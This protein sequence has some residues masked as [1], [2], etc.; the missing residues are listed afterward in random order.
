MMKPG[1]IKVVAAV[2]FSVYSIGMWVTSG[3]LDVTWLRWFSATTFVAT[4]LLAA[5]DLFLWRFSLIQ[6]IPVTP[7]NLRGTWKGAVVSFWRDPNY[8]VTPPPIEAYLVVRQTATTVQVTLITEESK[9]TSTLARISALNG[10]VVLDYLYF[11][12]PRVSVQGRSPMH[13]GSVVL[14]ISGNPPH[15]MTGRY[16]TDRDTKGELRFEGRSGCLADDF[17]DAKALFG[18]EDFSFGEGL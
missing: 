7:R 16:W 12:R 1:L 4:V 17:T 13:H 15:R 6:K 5:W 10:S 2:V 3:E 18:D 14:D 8:G 11:N 9:S